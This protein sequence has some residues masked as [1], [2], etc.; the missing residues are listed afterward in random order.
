MKII[1]DVTQKDIDSASD[2]YGHRCYTCPIARAISR[3]TKVKWGVGREEAWPYWTKWQ[4]WMPED[5]YINH[6]HNSPKILLP[7]EA[8]EFEQ[9][10]D[11]ETASGPFQ[12][13]VIPFSFELEI[14]DWMVV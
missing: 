2:G 10:F 14:P 12:I 5:F 11:L 3:I 4:T 9:R 7:L 13:T 1:I 8:V 6:I